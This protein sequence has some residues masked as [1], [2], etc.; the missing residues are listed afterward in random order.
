MIANNDNQAFVVYGNDVCFYIHSQIQDKQY[1]YCNNRI[2]VENNFHVIDDISGVK[3][4]IVMTFNEFRALLELD[5]SIIAQRCVYK[6]PLH[7]PRKSSNGYRFFK[8][9]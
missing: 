7:Q 1:F 6:E 2:L 3:A 4:S 8:T 5:Q 9:E